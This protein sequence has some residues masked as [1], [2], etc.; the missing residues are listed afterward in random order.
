MSH[1][2]KSIKTQCLSQCSSPLGG[3]T[4]LLCAEKKRLCG[5]WYTPGTGEPC[6]EHLLRP[7]QP[8]TG[9]EQMPDSTAQHPAH[10]TLLLQPSPPGHSSMTMTTSLQGKSLGAT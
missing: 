8:R 1:P 6:L 2:D 7:S 3:A 4:G 9:N 5:Q 10:I